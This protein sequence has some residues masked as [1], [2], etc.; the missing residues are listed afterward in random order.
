M[1][2]DGLNLRGHRLALA[3]SQ[4]LRPSDHMTG[5]DQLFLFMHWAR[6]AE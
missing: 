1:S 6:D 4:T 5:V 3:E 2:S